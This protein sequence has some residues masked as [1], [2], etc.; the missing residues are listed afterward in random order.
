MLLWRRPE[1]SHS[2]ITIQFT[3]AGIECNK[4]HAHIFLVCCLAKQVERIQR[5]GTSEPGEVMIEFA[6]PADTFGI[7]PRLSGV[8]NCAG[9]IKRR[10]YQNHA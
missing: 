8:I 10:S 9:L 7:A 5:A 1:S 4:S 6:G 3:P 2:F